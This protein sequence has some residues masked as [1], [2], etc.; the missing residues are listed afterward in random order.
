MSYKHRGLPHGKDLMYKSLRQ[1]LETIIEVY[2][3]NAK[4]LASLGSNQANEAVN[5]AIES[6]AP[7]IRHNGS[8]ESN[9]FRVAC[10]VGQKNLGHSYVSQKKR[11]A[12]KVKRLKKTKQLENREGQQYSF[13]MVFDGHNAAQE[14]PASPA[15]SKIERVSLTK[16]YHQI[17]FDWETSGRVIIGLQYLKT[18]NDA[19]I[20]QIAATDGK[21]E[22]SIY[23]KPSNVISPE[24]STVNKL[25]FQRGILF[26]DGK[27]I[28][29]AVAIDVALKT[30]IEWLKSRMP[31]I[32]VAHNC[33]SFDARFL[34]QEAEKN[35]VMDD[36]V[37]TVSG[38]TDSLSAFREL[39]PERKFHSQENLV[40]DL[41]SKS[42]EAHNA[43]A[44]VQTLYQLVN[45]FLNVKLL[46]KHSFKVSWAASYQKLL[47]EKKLLVNTLQPLV[48]EKYI[49]A[50]MAIKCT[51]SGLGLPHLQV[52]YQRGKEEGVKQVL[53]ERFDN[54]PRVSSNKRVLAQMCRY[55]IDNTN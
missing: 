40:Q 53:M 32:L 5:N 14:I 44:D 37:K 27:P 43:L 16:D 3:S 6:K 30:F 1:Y 22:F 7:K 18:G 42:Y 54:K 50:S 45:K 35:G 34:V 20:L 10:A 49:S 15:A 9:D 2:A 33:K 23:I 26:Y 12:K 46:H 29:D 25:T 47:K 28:T 36:L 13:G 38:F 8:S 17:M 24:A 55:F 11:I 48:R 39:L 51:S 52:V 31:C 4:K 19:E 41:L 21:D